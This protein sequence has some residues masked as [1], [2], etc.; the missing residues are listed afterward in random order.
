MRKSAFQ[1]L[2]S[3]FG[4]QILREAAMPGVQHAQSVGQ[5]GHGL[6]QLAFLVLYCLYL[7]VAFGKHTL[8]LYG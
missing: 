4:R 3:S 2:F 7:V 5:H 8:N 1:D 6:V